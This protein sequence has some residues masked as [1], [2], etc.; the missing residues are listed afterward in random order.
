MNKTRSQHGFT[1][2]ELLVVIAVISLLVSILLPS[3]NR[4]KDLAKQVVCQSNMKQLVLAFTVYNHD[5]GSY[6]PA[7]LTHGPEGYRKWPQQLRPYAARNINMYGPNASEE[8]VFKCPADMNYYADTQDYREV[9]Y[10]INCYEYGGIAGIH[11]WGGNGKWD[12]W[13]RSGDIRNPSQTILLADSGHSGED[14]GAAYVLFPIVSTAPFE[15]YEI[16][17]RHNNGANMLF[18]DS[19]VEFANSDLLDWIT[20]N[21]DWWDLE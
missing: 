1:L 10:G 21:S 11:T 16:Y 8:V 7:C 17:P 12:Y 14:G 3:L 15:G 6:Y 4:A 20:N 18:A 9:S 2:I 19:H 5:Y 13:T